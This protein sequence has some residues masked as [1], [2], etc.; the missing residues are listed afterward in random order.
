MI[1]GLKRVSVAV[2]SLEDAL[3][4][5]RDALGLELEASEE[6]PSQR[7]R[8]GSGVATVLDTMAVTA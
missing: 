5:Y 6:V 8:A 7:V 1:K 3:A 4:F 2:H